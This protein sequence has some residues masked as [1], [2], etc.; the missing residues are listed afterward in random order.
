MHGSHG[1]T[2]GDRDVRRGL[3][4]S[5]VI[6]ANMSCCSEEASM[7]L[8][9]AAGLELWLAGCNKDNNECIRFHQREMSVSHVRAI[10]II[11]LISG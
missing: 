3:A 1:D 5:P 8:V 2:V 10:A 11:S 7:L 6:S 4:L 9:T